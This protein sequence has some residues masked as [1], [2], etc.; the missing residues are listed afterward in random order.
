MFVPI[1]KPFLNPINCMTINLPYYAQIFPKG[2]I[3]L[4]SAFWSS[5]LDNKKLET[6][7]YFTM[8]SFTLLDI[9]GHNKIWNIRADFE[10]K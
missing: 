3:I 10:I 2:E 9:E 4:E 8:F 7:K 1:G 6:G 5:N